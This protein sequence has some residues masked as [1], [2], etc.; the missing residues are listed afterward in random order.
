ML[1]QIVVGVDARECGGDAVAL[2]KLLVAVDA[3]SRSPMSSVAM[4]TRTGAPPRR[5]KLPRGSVRRRCSKLCASSGC[6]SARA[7]AWI[8]VCGTRPA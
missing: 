7:L 3:S 4:G 5:T 2:A 8:F 1:K 6:R